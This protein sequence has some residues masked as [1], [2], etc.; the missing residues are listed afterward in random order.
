MV[1]LSKIG[2]GLLLNSMRKAVAQKF[3]SKLIHLEKI[4]TYFLES[5]MACE[6]MVK[7]E[8]GFYWHNQDVVFFVPLIPPLPTCFNTTAY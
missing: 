1:L 2:N 5:L 6:L 4:C 3:G 7:V 8:L